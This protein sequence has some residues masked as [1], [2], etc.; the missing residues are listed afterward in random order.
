MDITGRRDAHKAPHHFSETKENG[1]KIG[2]SGQA[3]RRAGERARARAREEKTAVAVEWNFLGVA[4]FFYP[5]TSLR[6]F[7]L[8]ALFVFRSAIDRIEFQN[9]DL[10]FVDIACH[11]SDLL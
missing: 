3:G 6:F 9:L 1:K 7:F 10:L 8:A 5:A 11:L 2:A 4:I